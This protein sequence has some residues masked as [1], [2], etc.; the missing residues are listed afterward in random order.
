LVRP[1]GT[2]DKDDEFA[3]ITQRET[4]CMA[5]DLIADDLSPGVDRESPVTFALFVGALEY[6]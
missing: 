4:A 1:G 3:V 5:N 6:S 2:V